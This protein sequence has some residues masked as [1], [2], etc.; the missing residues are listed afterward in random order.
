MAVL[1]LVMVLIAEVMSLSIQV[2]NP[3]REEHYV[4]RLAAGL[5][6]WS[7]IGSEVC[8]MIGDNI[9]TQQYN[10][11][12]NEWVVFNSPTRIEMVTSQL[13]GQ[14]NRVDNNIVWVGSRVVG[15]TNIKCTPKRDQGIR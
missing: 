3:Q 13:T 4:C 15:Q 9:S 1:L 8:R 6:I 2:Q 14:E 7:W 10:K 5:W 11:C 12:V